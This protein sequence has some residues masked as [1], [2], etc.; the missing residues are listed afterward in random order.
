MLRH[1]SDAGLYLLSRA[2]IAAL[3]MA[4]LAATCTGCSS[5]PVHPEEFRRGESHNA[6]GGYIDACGDLP[7]LVG[8]D[9]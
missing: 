1:H 6:A 9:C 2:A 8:D 3:L 5:A 4:L 7:G